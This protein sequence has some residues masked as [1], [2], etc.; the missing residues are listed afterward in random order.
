[1][2]EVFYIVLFDKKFS[3]FFNTKLAYKWVII[4]KLLTFDNFKNVK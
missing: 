3:S 1:M 2:V 4:T